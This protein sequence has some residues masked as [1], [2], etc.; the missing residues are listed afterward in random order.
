VRDT[1][2]RELGATRYY[3]HSSS[4]SAWL[5]VR[6]VSNSLFIKDRILT[7]TPDR[8][9]GAGSTAKP[10]EVVDVYTRERWR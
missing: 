6:T 10:F 1:I 5:D 8:R 7:F 4:V 9:M 3:K 2:S